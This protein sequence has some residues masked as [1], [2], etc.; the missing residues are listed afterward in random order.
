MASTL[1]TY[2]LSTGPKFP[3]NFEYLARRFVKVTLVGETR[4]E[5]GLNI[6]YRFTSKMEIELGAGTVT[7]SWS[8]IEIRRA[9]SSADRLVNFTDGS[10]LRS[11]DLNISQIQAIHIAEEGRD[12]AEASM[13]NDSTFWD[14]LG[15]PIKN[16]ADPVSNQ[17]A[18]TKNYVD[19]NIRRTMRVPQGETLPEMPA[20]DVRANKVLA[21]DNNGNYVFSAPATGSAADLA[22]QLQKPSGAA[23]VG[24]ERDLLRQRITDIHS[25]LDA[26]DIHPWEFEHLVVKIDPND[27][28]SWDWAPALNAM[29]V[30]GF[31][32][33]TLP[34]LYA[35]N[36][37]HVNLRVNFGGLTYQTRST[38]FIPDG[39]G[40][41]FCNGLVYADPKRPFTGTYLFEI[42]KRDAGSFRNDNLKFHSMV[43]DGRHKVG[44]V[45][46]SNALRISFYNCTAMR[47]KTEGIRTIGSCVEVRAVACD[48]GVT[49]WRNTNPDTGD[50]SM[51]VGD[52]TGL[53]L[54]ST[55]NRILGCIFHRGRSIIASAQ[56]Q[57]ITACQFYGSDPWG[58]AI[59][60]RSSGITIN[61]NAFGKLGIRVFS[62]FNVTITGNEFVMEDTQADD[63]AIS[64]NPQAA[65][66]WMSGVIIHSNTHRKVGGPAKCDAIKYD[67][68]QGTIARVRSSRI[69]DNVY[70]GVRP[71]CLTQ[72]DIK[73]TISV[74]STST[75]DFSGLIKFGIPDKVRVEFLQNRGGSAVVNIATDGNIGQLT[76]ADCPVKLTAAASGTIQ[77]FMSVEEGPDLS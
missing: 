65:G 64:L 50:T 31:S 21:F 39:G 43:W 26:Q 70:Y 51:V 42:G 34:M 63:W 16:L 12:Y 74:A 49:T 47:Y 1:Y 59:D 61:D 52:Q 67:T 54:G 28:N 66:E 29:L 68:S 19:G 18:A 45:A 15:M 25:M 40:V 9:T 23:L 60:V 2:D 56:A 41:S 53:R 35:N 30:A 71:S 69:R 77:G 55:D 62:P 48:F 8:K 44:C 38:V 24:W 75:L 33:I 32:R 73:K 13:R 57:H 76:P 36:V 17:D 46:V 4:L 14:S 7:T 5:L 27:Q 11:Y 58:S 3:V 6:D 72:A 20:A 37:N 22:I 10:I